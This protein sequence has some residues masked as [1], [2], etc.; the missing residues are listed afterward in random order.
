MP[1]GTITTKIKTARPVTE[2]ELLNA[3]KNSLDP[4]FAHLEEKLLEG[5]G[6]VLD[7][8][9]TVKA[10]TIKL[11]YGVSH[12]PA[13][14]KSA[15]TPAKAR[16]SKKPKRKVMGALVRHALFGFSS[17]RRQGLVTS[18]IPASVIP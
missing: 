4:C 7:I 9:V 15:T 18:W 6:K 14:V 11:E 2:S 5:D 10:G 12:C 3:L 16:P 13:N 8:R 17:F 1:K